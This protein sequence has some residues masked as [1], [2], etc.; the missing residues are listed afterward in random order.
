MMKDSAFYTQN[1]P[2]T[3]AAF[4]FLKQSKIMFITHNHANQGKISASFK[5]KQCNGVVNLLCFPNLRTNYKFR[6]LKHKKPKRQD[7]FCP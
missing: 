7:K 3:F 6:E 5:F 1:F 4:K 2:Q